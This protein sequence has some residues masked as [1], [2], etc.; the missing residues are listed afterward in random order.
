MIDVREWK[1][2]YMALLTAIEDFQKKY[3]DTG[4]NVESPDASSSTSLQRKCYGQK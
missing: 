4:E 1:H 3:T 2:D